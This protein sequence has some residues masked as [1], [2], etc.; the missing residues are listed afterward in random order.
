MISPEVPGATSISY[1]VAT[2]TGYPDHYAIMASSTG[3][4]TSNFT[5]VFEEDAP[6]AKGAAAGGAKSSINGGGHR[7]MSSWT[8]RTVELPAGTK[9]VAFRHYNSYDMNYL[10]IDDVTI[11]AGAKSDDRHLEFYKVIQREHCQSVL[12]AQHRRPC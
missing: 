11:N 2:N 7:E 9:Y 3:T 1:Y 5:M 8:A 12:P 6:I 4:N 10:F